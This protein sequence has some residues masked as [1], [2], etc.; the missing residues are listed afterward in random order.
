MDTV[1]SFLKSKSK[2]CLLVSGRAGSGKS[3]FASKLEQYIL[4]EYWKEQ[5]EHDTD[6]NVKNVVLIWANL[7]TLKNPLTNLFEEALANKYYFQ[8]NQVRELRV[9]IQKEESKIEPIFVLDA[10]DELRPE[11]LFRNLFKTNNLESFRPIKQPVS[12]D[13]D[14]FHSFPKVVILCRREILAGVPDYQK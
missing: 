9:E 13:K 6:Q 7:P 2:G 4:G 11:F 10:Y 5:Q 1:K 12:L 14:A 8:P 3:V